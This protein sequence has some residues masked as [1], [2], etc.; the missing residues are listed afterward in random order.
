[1]TENCQR[2]CDP[3]ERREHLSRVLLVLLA[4]LEAAWLLTISPLIPGNCCLLALIRGMQDSWPCVG[5]L[6]VAHFPHSL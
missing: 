2:S 3:G 5:E 1:M 6:S 4:L